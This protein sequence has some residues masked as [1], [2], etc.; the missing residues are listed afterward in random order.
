[1]GWGGG[2]GE[3]EECRDPS[4]G[5]CLQWALHPQAGG[6][7]DRGEALSLV[8]PPAG[9]GM[10]TCW[11]ACPS[12]L[13]GGR[14]D[15]SDR[16]GQRVAPAAAR[17]QPVRV[18]TLPKRCLGPPRLADGPGVTQEKPR[19]GTPTPAH[20]W[21]RMLLQGFAPS[22]PRQAG[23]ARLGWR[24]SRAGHLTPSPKLRS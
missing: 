4:R 12:V 5:D 7:W 22:R 3:K 8:C 20:I 24:G 17:G 6:P 15:R 21:P 16:E 2:K 19:C 13:A 23:Q 9:G 11:A 1:M 18:L 10:W 14:L